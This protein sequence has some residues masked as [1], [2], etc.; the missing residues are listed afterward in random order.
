M[1]RL[2][3]RGRVECPAGEVDDGAGLYNI[4][5][6]RDAS[7]QHT[8]Y[9]IR[10]TVWSWRGQRD[11]GLD[12]AAEAGQGRLPGSW[13]SRRAA[14]PFETDTSTWSTSCHSRDSAIPES[15]RIP[16]GC[17]RVVFLMWSTP[18][19]GGLGRGKGAATRGGGRR[20]YLRYQAKLWEKAW[21]GRGERA[22][23]AALG[24][25]GRAIFG[26]MAGRRVGQTLEP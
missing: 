15:R 3:T 23:S 12:S 21:Y 17:P 7:V 4:L 10:Q 19:L 11:R 16:G 9:P 14:L 18:E 24:K 8:P 22:S 5:S 6:S 2:S 20:P 26:N 13:R 25:V 1:A